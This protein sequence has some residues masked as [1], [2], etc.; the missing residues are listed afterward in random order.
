MLIRIRRRKVSIEETINLQFQQ[1]LY[2]PVGFRGREVA[3]ISLALRKV[4]QVS[5]LSSPQ[6]SYFPLSLPLPLIQT[7][8]TVPDTERDLESLNATIECEQPQPD[9]YKQALIM[10]PQQGYTTSMCC[11]QLVGQCIYSMPVENVQSCTV[12]CKESGEVLVSQ[13]VLEW[14]YSSL[15]YA[16]QLI[17]IHLQESQLRQTAFGS[18]L[19]QGIGILSFSQA[20]EWCLRRAK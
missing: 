8:Y 13:S 18:P 10:W 3:F 9:L 11:L 1:L 14:Q 17:N 19:G 2:I 15:V 16:A 12:D 20:S 4:L 5:C 7:H 6:D